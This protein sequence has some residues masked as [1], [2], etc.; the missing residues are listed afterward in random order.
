MTE[1]PSRMEGESCEEWCVRL[2]A[3]AHILKKEI[4]DLKNVI[5]SMDEFC[6][7]VDRVEELKK[8]GRKDIGDDDILRMAEKVMEE[9]NGEW[10]RF[11]TCDDWTLFGA[12]AMRRLM[13]GEE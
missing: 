10:D 4:R 9:R 5:G 7:A 6:R 3:Y 1:F 8:L 12:E 2:I 11:L 13:E